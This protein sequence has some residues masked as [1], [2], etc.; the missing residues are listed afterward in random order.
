MS[1]HFGIK[2]LITSAYHPQTNG[3]CERMNGQIVMRCAKLCK[4]MYKSDW[5][6]YLVPVCYSIRCHAQKSTKFTPF[7]VF[8]GRNARMMADIYD[9][10]DSNA[11]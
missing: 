4:C 5:D 1:R 8:Y 11:F 10:N 6:E 9:L 2:R 3:L 7:F